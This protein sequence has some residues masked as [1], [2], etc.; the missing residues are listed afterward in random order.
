MMM[1]IQLHDFTAEELPAVDKTMA[2][3]AFR[4]FDWGNELQRMEAAVTRGEECCPPT[5]SL[6][7]E[8]GN[9]LRISPVD[10]QYVEFE[11]QYMAIR[12][13]FVYIDDYVDEVHSVAGYPSE[14]VPDLIGLH[15]DRK[16][17][18]ILQIEET[19]AD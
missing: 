7:S 10:D 5:M 4:R 13:S 6:L 19:G 17:A 8:N 3:E 18:E 12:K 2:I 16:D 14:R 11:F 9:Q 15:F 1:Q